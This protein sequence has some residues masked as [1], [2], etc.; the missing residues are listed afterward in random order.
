[1]RRLLKY[2]I[3]VGLAAA[4]GGSIVLGPLS[5]ENSVPHPAEREAG[6]EVE[7]ASP[8]TS[9]SIDEE[10]DYMVATR[11]GSLEGWHAFLAAH[12]NGAYG[13]AARAE[14]ERRL[15]AADA[16]ATAPVAAPASASTDNEQGYGVAQRL[17]SLASY[18]QSATAKVEQLLFADRAA[19]PGNAEVSTGAP[20]DA[21]A[22]SESTGPV[23]PPSGDAVPATAPAAVS[24]AS[25]D[26]KAMNEAARP[27]APVAETVGAAGTQLAALAPDEICQRDR[28][29]LERLRSNPSSDELVRFAI[30]LG[31]KKLL[32]QVVSLMMSLSPP[33]AAADVSTTAPPDTQAATEAARPASHVAGADVASL[34][35]DE[36]CKRDGD[37]LAR[38]RANPS[39]E[40]AQRFASELSCE[41]LRPQLQRLME[42]LG[43][44][45]PAPP[46]P[47]NSSL[48]SSSL[49]TEGCVSERAELD[50]LRKEPSAEAAGVFWRDLHCEGLRPQVR[51]LME[52]LNVTPEPLG[53]VAEGRHGASSDARAS[54]GADPVICR[55]E[56]AELN[57]IRATPD[58]VDAKHFASAVT[59][60]ALKPQA[61]RLLESLKE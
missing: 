6:A 21:R 12:G 10:L 47:A 8:V 1:M 55:R 58:L 26:A 48:P 59:C 40:Q 36:A 33:P 13:P 31:C 24:D 18:A 42:G 29:R 56:T 2:A 22:V 60:D 16:S 4:I 57:R 30:E 27:A 17:E 45:A 61:A 43:F 5:Y 53:S 39:G 34:T 50:R 23:S 9:A 44:V 15:G 37:R 28:E 46:G 52:S 41:A 38:L 7:P 54:N 11:L 25:Q 49:P 32:P 51:L 3:I 20:S 14:V 35:S 19:A